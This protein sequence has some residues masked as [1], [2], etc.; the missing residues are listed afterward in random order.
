MPATTLLDHRISRA[1]DQLK[2]ARRNGNH[3]R[4]TYWRT[5]VDGLLDLKLKEHT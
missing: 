3:E 1:Y 5:Q 4:I 2:A